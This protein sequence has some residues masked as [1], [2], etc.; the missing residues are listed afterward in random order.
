MRSQCNADHFKTWVI[1]QWK[2]EISP[3]EADI[4]VGG[5]VHRDG[6]IFTTVTPLFKVVS[7]TAVIKDF[8]IFQFDG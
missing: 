8:L 7:F 5:E 6:T 1:Q 3:D 4:L 2:K